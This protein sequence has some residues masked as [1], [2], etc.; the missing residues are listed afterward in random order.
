MTKD[1]QGKPLSLFKFTH[2]KGILS[3]TFQ[4]YSF[5]DK[6][7][8]RKVGVQSGQRAIVSSN[9]IALLTDIIVREY[10]ENDG[11]NLQYSILTL[12]D[13]DPKLTCIQ[14]QWYLD[15]TFFKNNSGSL[16]KSLVKAQRTT[17]K[18]IKITVSQKYWW[19][20]K[21]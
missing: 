4:K 6:A 10:R 19:F 16:K 2:S 8:R 1:Y 12:Q 17:T 18:H 5:K 14:T 13:I 15:Q 21:Y 20:K 11:L 3:Y 7:K 9:N